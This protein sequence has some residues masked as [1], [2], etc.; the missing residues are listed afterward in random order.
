MDHGDKVVHSVAETGA[1]RL[2]FKCDTDRG[3]GLEKESKG[4]LLHAHGGK[5]ID[6]IICYIVRLNKYIN[7]S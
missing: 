6:K 7:K 5:R 1:E 2:E 3:I 4:R